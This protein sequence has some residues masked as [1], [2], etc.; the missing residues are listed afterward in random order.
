MIETLTQTLEAQGAFFGIE[1]KDV[2]IGGTKV[3]GK[4]GLVREDDGTPLGIVSTKYNFI[5]LRDKWDRLA[6]AIDQSGLN[7]KNATAEVSFANQGARVML[8][9]RFPNHVIEP[10]IGDITELEIR[11]KDSC[12]GRWNFS[13]LGAGRRLWCLNG[14][15]LADPIAAYSE[16][17]NGN[18]DIDLAAEKVVGIMAEFERTKELWEQYSK[19]KI[20]DDQAWRVF[21]LYANR[22]VDFKRGLGSAKKEWN[23]TRPNLAKTMFEQYEVKE[24][25]EIGDNAFGVLNTL[26]HHATHAKLREGKEAIG[27][28]LRMQTVGRVLASDYW[29]KRLIEGKKH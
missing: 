17:H 19:V 12:D 14:M 24:R 23:E 13:V 2:M 22:P 1:K 9:L 6:Q 3:V 8:T 15:T 18:L 27:L 26:T 16:Y 10:V 5:P 25:R 20:T 11:V 4:V 7:T 21:C 29:Q 28:D